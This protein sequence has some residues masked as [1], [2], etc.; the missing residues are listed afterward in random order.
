MTLSDIH[1]QLTRPDPLGRDLALLRTRLYRFTDDARHYVLAEWLEESYIVGRLPL[2]ATVDHVRSCLAAIRENGRPLPFD[3]SVAEAEGVD[4]DAAL[5]DRARYRHSPAPD[6]PDPRCVVVIVGAPRSG[7]SHLVNLLAREGQFGYFTTATCWAW[8]V[9][10]LHQPIRRLFTDVG[11][12]VFQVD[13][14]RTRTIP[15]LVMPGEAEDIY[16]RALPVYRHLAGHRYELQAARREDLGVLH[17]AVDAHLAF[18]G[19]QRFLTKSPFNSLRIPQLEE[20]WGTSARYVHIVRDRR[21]A[22]DSLRRNRFEFLHDGQPLSAEQAWR[23]FVTKVEQT[24]PSDRLLTL[25]HANLLA[26]HRNIIAEIL[27]WLDSSTLKDRR[28]PAPGSS[29]GLPALE[30]RI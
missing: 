12:E 10:N 1:A 23:I 9:R 15:A 26:D 30:G 5:A 24:A 7:T 28:S 16:A 18:F 25:T 4:I 11:P 20:I 27:D 21:G 8:P 13:N 14:R 22:A 2:A 19:R 17:R 3:S 6:T 29:E